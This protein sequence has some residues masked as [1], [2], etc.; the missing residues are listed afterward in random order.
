MFD[1]ATGALME[2]LPNCECFAFDRNDSM[3]ALAGPRNYRH[4]PGK[5]MKDYE[6]DDQSVLIRW[7]N[8]LK[9]KTLLFCLLSRSMTPELHYYINML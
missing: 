6:V 2:R 8:G 1:V 7:T 4:R 3:M 5:I 9:Q